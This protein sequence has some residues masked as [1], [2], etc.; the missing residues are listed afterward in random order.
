MPPKTSRHMTLA[1]CADYLN[2]TGDDRVRR[3]RRML[4][5]MEQRHGRAY[6]VRAGGQQRVRYLVTIS[7]LRRSAPELFDAPSVETRIETHDEQIADV[8]RLSQETAARVAELTTC[9]RVL[10]ARFGP[11]TAS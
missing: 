6:M 10:L 7:L 11:A 2:M 4:L 5:R 9:V 1:E 3:L 8:R